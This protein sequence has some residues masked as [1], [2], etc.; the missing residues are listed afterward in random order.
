M[1]L[2]PCPF[3][4]NKDLLIIKELNINLESAYQVACDDCGC[5]MCF[6]LF[7]DVAVTRW[8]T[9]HNECSEAC[10]AYMS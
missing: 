2:K 3:C 7:R 9:R 6:E 8:N 10:K 4:G 1:K 5:R